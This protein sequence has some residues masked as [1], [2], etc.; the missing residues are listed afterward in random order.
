MATAT[1][2]PPGVLRKGDD[3]E[4]LMMLCTAGHVD[5]GKTR[6]V[7]LLTGCATDRLKA[8]Q[9]RGLTIEL[10]FA[11]CTLGDGLC[12]GIV[13]VPGHE[14]F[15][16]TMVAGVSG[17]D[18]A[19]LVI[20][21]DDGIMPQT[22][23]HLQIMELL[24]VKR[25]IVALTKIDLVQTCR[26]QE[27]KESVVRFLRGTFLEGSPVCPLSSE[28]GEGIFDF[29]DNLKK[30][31]LGL[32]REKREGVFRMPVERTFVQKGFGKVI[33]GI[34]V[35]GSIRVGQQV[36]LAPDGIL[37]RI[38]TIQRFLRN[39]DE[40]HDGQCLALNVPEF[41]KLAVQRG[42]VIVEP[43]YLKGASM[44]HI[45]V[46]ALN[47]L[48]AP[49][50]NAQPVKMHTG[51][52][53]A[54]GALYLLTEKTLRP[55]ETGF[56]TLVLDRPIVAV[57]HDRLILRSP[58]PALTVAGGEVLE[59]QSGGVRPRRK[60]LAKR[61]ADYCAWVDTVPRNSDAF[62]CRR[63]HHWLRSTR[64]LGGRIEDLEH[65]LLI[66][67]EAIRQH[68][69]H[70]VEQGHV[71]ELDSKFLIEKTCLQRCRDAAADAL[72]HLEASNA[73]LA[74]TLTEL[75]QGR[76]WPPPVWREILAGLEAEGRLKVRGNKLLLAKAVQNL[77]LA[78]Q[79]LMEAIVEAYETTGFQSPRPEDIPDLVHAAPATVAKML[80]ALYHSG[81]LVRLSESVV[82]S[83][84]HYKEAQAIVLRLI[85]EH[86]ELDSAD[87]KHHIASSRKY[88]LAILDQLDRQKVTV[89]VG[90]MRKLA[91][92][93]EA[94]LL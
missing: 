79:G 28:T 24:G 43:G 93:Y 14:K 27:V 64:W 36:E 35:S 1:L 40:G 52:S 83:G 30:Q 26:T 89:R 70:L 21:A 73:Q 69:R 72:S 16:R 20:A 7:G 56:A 54:N 33:T 67:P 12:V 66:S 84:R 3:P 10:G 58:S 22:V 75:Q 5:H 81:A 62:D 61:L 2:K 42:Q 32:T 39:T 38:R 90:N 86:G 78:E 71:L 47:T 37:G 85:R 29:Y 82:L 74:A 63:V 92:N 57:P 91:P 11:P 13:D 19:I 60:V 88:A 51:T 94:H 31:I 45:C 50:K 59:T 9:E 48:D 87:F 15:V 53:E 34:P 76:D 41:G 23:E 77:S 44:L 49:L 18:M 17:I 25:G 6:L 46:R 55:G 65:N 68:V 4:V 80:D 8:E